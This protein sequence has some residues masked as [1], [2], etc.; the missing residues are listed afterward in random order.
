MVS[1]P[2]IF[3]TTR[4]SG[5]GSRPSRQASCTVPVLMNSIS[6]MKTMRL[7]RPSTIVVGNASSCLTTFFVSP[8]RPAKKAS[9]CHMSALVVTLRQTGSPNESPFLSTCRAR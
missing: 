3:L 2:R 9:P 1:E 5:Q 4:S 6:I 8:N 7:V